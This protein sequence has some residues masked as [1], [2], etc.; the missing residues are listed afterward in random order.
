[1]LGAIYTADNVTCDGNI[2]TACGPAAA[3]DLGFTFV[4]RLSGIAKADVLRRGM[5]F[6]RQEN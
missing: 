1:M 5:Q 2:L 4:E 3:W 6:V